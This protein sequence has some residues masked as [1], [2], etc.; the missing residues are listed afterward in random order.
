MSILLNEFCSFI[1]QIKE[2]GDVLEF[3]TGS[4]GST[5]IIANII[6]KKRKIFTF[7]GFEGLPETKKGIPAGTGWEKGKYF[8]D[9]NQVKNRLKHYE[10]VFIEKTMTWDLKD[11]KEYNINKII[12]VN[13]DLDLYEGTL[14]ALRFIDKCDWITILF[15]FDDWGSYPHQIASEVDAHEKAAFFDW[16]HE[17]KYQYIIDDNL[18]KTSFGL[19]S[20]IIVKR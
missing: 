4:G 12:A 2:P 11:P 3:G 10:N 18:V 20:I 13:M 7:D 17:T 1:N 19:Q 16:I 5:S 6:S 14:D 15:R 9:I 8:Y